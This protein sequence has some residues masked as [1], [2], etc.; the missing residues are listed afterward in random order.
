MSNK[1]LSTG[2]VDTDVTSS[3]MSMSELAGEAGFESAL[4]ESCCACS[5][6]FFF[7][8]PKSP[9]MPFAIAPPG[10]EGE[11]C[12]LLSDCPGWPVPV[13]PTLTY[14][15]SGNPVMLKA[16]LR[17]SAIAGAIWT[18]PAPLAI[19]PGSQSSS[20]A[21]INMDDAAAVQIVDFSIPQ[22]IFPA[23]LIAFEADRGV[24][25]LGHLLGV[26]AECACKF[27]RPHDGAAGDFALLRVFEIG[28]T[29]RNSE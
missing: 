8:L 10:V 23:H 16:F 24:H 12:A 11:D 13:P 7:F 17:N 22:I 15:S 19:S 29:S 26:F 28:K 18:L 9:P 21:S 3:V 27:H 4:A 25:S 2:S 6:S 14:C 20:V 5:S 1:D